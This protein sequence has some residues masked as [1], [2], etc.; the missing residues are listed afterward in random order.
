[1]LDVVTEPAVE[2]SP[3]YCPAGHSLGPG[4]VLIGWPL[5][6]SVGV[7]GLLIAIS[8]PNMLDEEARGLPAG[9]P[10]WVAPVVAVLLWVMGAWCSCGTIA[11]FRTRGRERG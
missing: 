1:M 3:D 11:G 2:A 9:V 10:E 8:V 6:L 5:V 7:C 4:E